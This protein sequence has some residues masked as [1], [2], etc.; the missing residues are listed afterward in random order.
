MLLNTHLVTIEYFLSPAEVRL[1]STT[2][3]LI[4]L[5]QP[6][7]PVTGV[8]HSVFHLRLSADVQEPLY[9][10]GF[11]CHALRGEGR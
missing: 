11:F 5:R 1:C 7:R 10:R 2:R 8:S 6:L 3:A 9:P 4:Q